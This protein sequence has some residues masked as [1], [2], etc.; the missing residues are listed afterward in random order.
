MS[1][2]TVADQCLAPERS[3]DSAVGWRYRRLFPH[4]PPLEVDEEKLRALGR[5]GGVCDA[6][7]ADPADDG[8]MAAGWPFYGQLIAHDITAD[9]TPIGQRADPE[10]IVNFRTP[11]A[12]LE[13]VYGSG[14][15]GSPYLYRRDDPAKLLVGEGGHDIPRNHEGIALVGDPRND[16]HLFVSQLQLAFIDS[17]NRLVDSVRNDGVGETDVFEAARRANTWHNQWVMLHEFL[18][19]LVGAELVE[20]V[21]AGD[22]QLLR[23][24]EAPYLPFEFA[25][26]AY[27]YGHSQVRDTY[28]INRDF[29]P[30]PV[31]PDLM[32]FGAVPVERAIDWTLQFDIPGEREA[33]R[34]KKIDGRLPGCLIAM[35]RQV[36]GEVEGSDFSSL[37]N[38]DLERGQLVGLASGEAIAGAMGIEPLS[39]EQIGLREIGW[40]DE[41]PLWLYVLKEAETLEDGDR[42]GPVASRIVAEVLVGIVDSDPESFRTLEPDWTPTMPSRDPDRFSLTD[43]L[44]PPGG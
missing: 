41:T 36:T 3:G 2:A 24:E 23:P 39:P 5:R 4:L 25:D 9:R 17:H 28:R 18:P 7:S 35:P 13:A 26:G 34:A 43:I 37:A 29:G 8:A 44:L 11:R 6:D 40:E 32:G 12:N 27:R 21:M 14:P 33:Q 1:T 42:L 38:R 31:F 15:I 22:W 19:Q 16:V 10:Q 30:V 20:G